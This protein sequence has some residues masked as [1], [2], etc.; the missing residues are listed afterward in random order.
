MLIVL[1]VD[2]VVLLF[3]S[4]LFH[5]AVFGW[6]IMLGL[7]SAGTGGIAKLLFP[8]GP[9][10]R[11]SWNND[12]GQGSKMTMKTLKLTHHILLIKASHMANSDPRGKAKDSTF[13]RNEL[14][15]AVAMLLDL[16]QTLWC[17]L[18][19]LLLC[20][21]HLN[22]N[23]T[24]EMKMPSNCIPKHFSCTKLKF[25]YGEALWYLPY[26]NCKIH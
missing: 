17:R 23:D 10:P 2:Y 4:A 22:K 21:L 14:K 8:C 3:S 9:P 24:T 5:A 13:W 26:C 15:N 19:Y 16:P 12:P 25:F 18:W 7:D 20:H 1:Q 11:T 6:Q